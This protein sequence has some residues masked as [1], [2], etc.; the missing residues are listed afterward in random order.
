MMLFCWLADSIM[1]SSKTSQ[2]SSILKVGI[3]IFST[4]GTCTFSIAIVVRKKKVWKALILSQE[5]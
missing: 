1:P 2:K 3:S 4:S 5:D